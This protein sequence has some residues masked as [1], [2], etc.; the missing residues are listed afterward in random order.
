MLGAATE[1]QPE[2][3]LP[4]GIVLT[5]DEVKQF[6]LEH[7]GEWIPLPNGGAIHPQAAIDILEGEIGDYLEIL[8]WPSAQ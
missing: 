7:P 8:K 4:G 1:A 5:V 2:K 3:Y 6:Q